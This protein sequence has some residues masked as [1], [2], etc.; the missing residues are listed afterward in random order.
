MKK[1]TKKI[2]LLVVVGPTASGKTKLAIELAHI[3]D[4]EIVSA[5]SMQIYKHMQIG[6]AKP[7][8]YEM[9]GIPH[10]LIDFVEPDSAAFSVADYTKLANAAIEEIYVRGKLPILVG[11]TGL[12]IN[13]VVNQIDYEKIESDPKI[14][15]E[16][17]II[18]QAQGNEYMLQLLHCID[19]ALAA[20][21]HPN[22]LGRILR[23]LEVYR[24]TGV[25]MS[26]HQRRSRLKPSSYTPCILGI[27]YADRSKLYERINRRVD[28][29]LEMGLV[30]ETRKITESYGGTA[31]QAIGYK[32]L[33]P[34]LDGAETLEVC[35]ERLKQAT[36]HYAKRQLTWFRRDER[37]H[38]LM[39]D[40][41]GG[42][43]KIL[44]LAQKIVHTSGIL[45]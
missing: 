24:V 6:T 42:E 28:L 9:Q 5:D 40:Q 33:Q 15:E 14:R 32:E 39:V 17:R 27:T 20:T 11:G 34:Y 31:R 26:E 41:L 18:A 7:T 19:P 25:T 30:E 4:G 36:R 21:L 12:Y 13:A 2:P 37:V 29:M 38:W 23:A 3:F 16:L 8:N 10:H 1:Q 43:D 22:N 35:V 44:D 45:C